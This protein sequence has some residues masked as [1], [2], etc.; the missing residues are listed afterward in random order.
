MPQNLSSAACDFNLLRPS[1]QWAYTVNQKKAGP[2]FIL[3]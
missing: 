2:F 1:D 3:A